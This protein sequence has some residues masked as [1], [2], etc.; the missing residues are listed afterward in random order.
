MFMIGIMM[1]IAADDTEGSEHAS[2]VDC[3]LS[4]GYMHQ[5]LASLSTICVYKLWEPLRDG[6]D[7]CELSRNWSCLTPLDNDQHVD[8]RRL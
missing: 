8:V 1:T 5:G 4:Q 3:R 6:V 7:R 2:T